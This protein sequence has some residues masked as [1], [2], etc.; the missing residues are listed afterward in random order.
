MDLQAGSSVLV[1]L[2][3]T[4]TWDGPLKFISKE[5]ETVL[6]QLNEE[7]AFSE[8]NASDTGYAPTSGSE[9]PVSI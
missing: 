1:Y 2:T 5:M 8:A 7:V 4:N 3:I 9:T 6:V